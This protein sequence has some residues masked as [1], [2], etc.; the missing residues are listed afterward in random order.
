MGRGEHQGLGKRSGRYPRSRGSCPHRLP[1]LG[2]G[3]FTYQELFIWTP[4]QRWYFNEYSSS[5]DFPTTRGNYLLLMK[6]DRNGHHSVAGNG[7]VVPDF[8]GRHYLIPFELSDQ[9]R[10]QGAVQ[11]NLETVHY[12]SAQMER[13][14]RGEI[15][16]GR[17]V[18]E[19]IFPS[20]A[21]SFGFL[22]IGL[23]FAIPRDRA[24]R[25][26]R[27]EGT[28]LKGPQLVTVEEFN[29]WSGSD[30]INFLT[31]ER[32]RSLSIPRSLESSHIMIM[33]DTGAGKSVLQRHV[34][35]QVAQRGETAI[36]YDAALEYTP[37]F[38]NPARGD[39]I[40][41]P[42]DAR[43]PYWSPS[44]E[45]IH[46]AEALTL[47]K[48][49]FPD[50]P[51]ENQFFVEGPRKI[52]AHLLTLKPTPAELVGWMSHEEE[53]DRLL[54]GTELEA[55]VYRA[56]GPQRGGV[57]GALNMV[58]DSL[59]LLPRESD[60]KQ[61]W[62]TEEWARQKTGW[63]FLTSTPRFRE[64][65]LPLTSLWLDTLVLRL[66]NQGDPTMRHAWFVL[67]ELAS[68]Q[69]L[70]QLHTALTE[71]RK[72]ENPVVIGFQGRSQLE[73]RYG[74]EAETMLSQPATKIFLHT[75]EPR[76][77][78]WISDAIGQVEMER[79]K[80]TKYVSPLARITKSLGYHTERR[81]EPL[82]LPSEITGLERLHAF[83]KVGNMVVPFGFP[84][85]APLKSQQGFVPR[86]T[87][88]RVVEMG[89]R[90]PEPTAVPT[91]QEIGQPGL[92]ERP[93]G[94]AAGQK[95]YFQ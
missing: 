69:R 1:S 74:H 86:P 4:L 92:G 29:R 93:K 94:I 61:R 50:K 60:A 22:V 95:P 57:L 38:F 18:G 77:A 19:L 71:N 11:L 72:S 82:V 10:Q 70:P 25:R 36:V 68:L 46:E 20:C 81:T 66:M 49:L 34:L 33:G 6:T 40:L 55:F 89:K 12:S 32:K 13:I 27:D 7:D 14:L 37:Q 73:V 21:A 17:S 28:R 48:S 91:S 44:D 88:P 26:Q 65:L 90:A 62:T 54:K 83:L 5:H 52:F 85:T 79:V 31:T 39:L 80:E 15:F 45:V 51:Y 58:A 24:R 42:L 3:I 76:A 53:L 84:Y 35:I 30:G 41:N 8:R 59:K 63:L 2:I 23:A 64:R 75:S 67:D 78:K 43:C 9:A 56:A 87:A 47:A 16:A